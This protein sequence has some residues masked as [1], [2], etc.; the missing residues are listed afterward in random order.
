MFSKSAKWQQEANEMRVE[1]IYHDQLLFNIIHNAH[2]PTYIPAAPEELDFLLNKMH[3]KTQELP[4]IQENDLMLLYYGL[5]AN[6]IV[7]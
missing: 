7:K 2:A 5:P 1:I 6:C 4:R 3:T